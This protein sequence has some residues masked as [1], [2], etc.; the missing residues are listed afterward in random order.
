MELRE[1]VNKLLESAA[2]APKSEDALR[3][4]QAALNASHTKYAMLNP[5]DPKE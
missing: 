5:R 3:F 1:I 2:S 4:S